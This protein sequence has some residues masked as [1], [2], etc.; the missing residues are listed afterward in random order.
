MF[1]VFAFLVYICLLPKW[2]TTSS[3]SNSIKLGLLTGL[4]ILVRPSNIVVVLIPLLWGVTGV[5]NFK[6][7][8]QLFFKNRYRIISAALVAL[9]VF[10]LQIIYWKSVT[11]DLLYYSYGDEGFFFL[12]P[13]ILDGLLSYR[14]GWLIYTPVMLFALFGF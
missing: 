13:H 5:E 14:K 1:T 2:S 10:G 4:I 11:G 9:L 12:H 3:W 6:A 7:K 8:L